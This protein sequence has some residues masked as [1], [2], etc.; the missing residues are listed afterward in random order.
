[1]ALADGATMLPTFHPAYVLRL[2]DAAAQAR[3]RALLAE[4]LAR[5]PAGLAAVDLTWSRAA[6]ARRGADEAPA[7][8]GRRALRYR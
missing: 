8:Q 3:A 6:S 2:P 1:M 5:R 4:D 7:V